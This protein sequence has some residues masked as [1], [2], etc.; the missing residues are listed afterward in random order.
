M[1]FLVPSFSFLENSK[2]VS[3]WRECISYGGILLLTA[4]ALL[5]HGY[6]LGVED[7]TIYLPAIKKILDPS[8]Y[9]RDAEFFLAQ[10]RPTVFPQIV[11]ATVRISHSS[12][13]NAVLGWQV[14]SI[15][16]ILA[17]ARRWSGKLFASPAAQWAAVVM[18]VAVL[19]L[20]VA[21]TALYLVDPYLHLRAPAMALLLFM[22]ADVMERNLWRAALLAAIAAT[23]HIQMTF[24]ALLLA[25]FLLLPKRWF[26]WLGGKSE[27]ADRLAQTAVLAA[28][29]LQS[30]FEPGTPA[31]RE[32]ARTRW[33]HYLLRWPWHA[34]IGIFAPM[35]LLLWF[36]RMG[37]QRGRQ[38]IS[39][40][41]RRV[42]GFGIFVFVASAI[43]TMP[44]QLERL[45]PYQPMRG[46]HLIY[47]FL[48]LL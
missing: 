2:F 25:A 10:T 37:A 29:P 43:M 26:D 13:E 20:P 3:Y 32:A 39:D 11:A 7:Q 30:L 12:I 4:M 27:A 21:G 42:A 45:T 35:V 24:Y 38:T 23:I 31:W 44:P 6:H 33:Q 9:P 46:F 40:L 16:L 1:K 14:F 36:G 5:I 17:A 19:T 15:L 48:V 41:C 47:F 34:W 18:V 8:L 28:W 22:L